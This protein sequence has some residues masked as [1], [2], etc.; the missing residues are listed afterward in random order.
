SP[1]PPR[2]RAVPLPLTHGITVWLCERHA[3][4]EYQMR[5]DGL[6]LT[7]TL[8]RL[9]R[10]HGCLTAARRRALG[11]HRALVTREPAPRGRPG[12]YAWPE[13]RRLAEAEFAC[14]GPALP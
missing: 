1:A 2:D 3:S 5:R 4:P 9:W 13:L 8:E 7:E 12:S 14:G 10:A 6:E 11:G